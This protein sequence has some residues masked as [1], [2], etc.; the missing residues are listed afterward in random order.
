MLGNI[1]KFKQLVALS[2]ILATLLLSSLSAYA[3]Q[4]NQPGSGLS[5][6]PTESEFT[7]K[8]GAADI[9]NI[10]LKNIT[11]GDIV[12]KPT[13]NDFESDNVTGTPKLITDPNKH[14]PNSIRKFVSGLDDVPL[15]KGEQKKVTVTLQVPAK[16]TPGAYFGVIRYKAVPVGVNAPKEGQLTL[17]ASVGTIVLVTVPGNLHQ[18]VQVTA[19]HIY[20]GA[21]EGSLFISKPTQAGVELKNLG[22]DFAKPFGTVTVQKMFGKQVYSY[23]LNNS[24]PRSNVLPGTSRIFKDPIKNVSSPGRYTVTANVTYGN[25]N[26]VLVMKKDF[27][28]IPAWL[29]IIVLLIILALIAGVLRAWRRYRRGARR[30]K[31]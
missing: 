9:L 10:N 14:S 24:Q 28:Y 13:I 18:Q 3:Q 26:D 11:T 1:K 22:N 15:A 31:R 16:Y 19:V 6:S 7:V 27:W 29:A 20:R 25:G 8:P 30:F 4:G 5:I 23:Q 12:A 2:L 17:S 21:H